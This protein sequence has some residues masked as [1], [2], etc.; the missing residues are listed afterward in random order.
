MFPVRSRERVVQVRRL[1]DFPYVLVRL[2][3]ELCKRAG[4]YRLAR[5]AA[6]Y[7]S[8]IL[9]DDLIVR[10]SNDCPWRDDPRGSGCGARFSDLP[11]RR[12][13]DMPLAR[14]LRVVAGGKT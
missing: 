12:P 11:P 13:P 3:C 8:E 2:R 7:G 6:K 9:L 10:L 4:S 14:R 1:V 5:L